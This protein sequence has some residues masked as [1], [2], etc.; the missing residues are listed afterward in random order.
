MGLRQSMSWLHGWSGLLLGWLCYAIFLT[1][2]TAYFRQEITSW[3]RPEAVPSASVTTEE[4]ARVALARLQTLAPRAGQWRVELPDDRW[5]DLRIAWQM[6]GESGRGRPR[7]AEAPIQDA[8]PRAR[9]ADRGGGAR[10]DGPEGVAGAPSSGGESAAPRAA[11]SAAPGAP[12]A[13]A[14]RG[15]GGGRRGGQ[16]TTLDPVT[17][18]IVKPRET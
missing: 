17:S 5:N 1:G 15:G 18:E 11:A 12:A 16:M 3:M 2:T 10:R 9:G 14:S 8:R 6:P 7:A 4:A 13:G